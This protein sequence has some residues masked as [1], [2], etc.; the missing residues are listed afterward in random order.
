M[1]IY[2]P[3]AS[4]VKIIRTGNYTLSWS[5]AR[6]EWP[7]NIDSYGDKSF[8]ELHAMPSGDIWVIYARLEAIAMLG[9]IRGSLL[10]RIFPATLGLEN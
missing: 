4:F 7:A 2:L 5:R 3:P 9:N 6:L 8:I 1:I 10:L